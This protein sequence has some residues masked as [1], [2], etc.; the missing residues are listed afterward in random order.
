MSCYSVS[1]QRIYQRLSVGITANVECQVETLRRLLTTV[2][3]KSSSVVKLTTYKQLSDVRVHVG[4][5]QMCTVAS[6]R[7]CV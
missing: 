6:E 1:L 5:V 4:H 3:R 7:S 2:L